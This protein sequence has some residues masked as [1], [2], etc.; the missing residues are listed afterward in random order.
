MLVLSACGGNSSK[1]NEG[2]ANSGASSS[3]SQ[4]SQSKGGGSE[5]V[6]ITILNSK[7]ER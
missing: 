1:N 4:N 2:N 3:G 7:A 6:K 5:K